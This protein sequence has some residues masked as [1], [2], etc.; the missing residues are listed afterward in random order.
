MKPSIKIE[1]KVNR[2]LE[3]MNHLT[4]MKIAWDSLVSIQV[5]MFYAQNLLDGLL[6]NFP[7]T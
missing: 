1:G 4:C 6:N 5:S 3:M 7:E 2:H